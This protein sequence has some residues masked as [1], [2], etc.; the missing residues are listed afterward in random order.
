MARLVDGEGP[1]YQV[2]PTTCSIRA[3]IVPTAAAGPNPAWRGGGGGGEREGSC[4]PQ[5][6][7]EGGGRG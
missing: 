1:G 3:V 7:L 6:G 4:L 2:Q 5:P